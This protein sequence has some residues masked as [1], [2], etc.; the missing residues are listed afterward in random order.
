MVKFNFIARKKFLIT[1]LFILVIFSIGFFL[2]LETVSLT[3]IPGDERP[4]YQDDNG[5]PY[6]YELDSYYNYRL[7]ENYLEHGYLGDTI[8]NGVE[9]DLHSYYPPGVPL[10]Y[11]PLIVY[12]TAFVYKFVN[13]FTD[14]P[15]IVVCFWLSA[16]IAP[17]AGI[18]AYFFVGRFTNQYGAVAAGILTVTIPFYFIRTV[19]GWFDTDMFNLIFP[20]LVVWFLFEAFDNT[21]KSTQKG[22][23][24]SFLSA[25]SIFL[26]SMAWNG[27][28]YLFYLITIFWIIYIIWTL[29]KGRMVKN[30]LYNFAIF[31]GVS[32]GLVAVFTGFINIIKLAYAFLQLSTLSGGGP[33][34]DW[35]NV[36]TSV[37][38]LG[39]PS[40]EEISLDMGLSLF[41][42]LF[43]LIWIFRILLNDKLQQKFL[44]RMNWLSFSFLLLWTIM[45]FVTLKQG[46]RF[47]MILIPPLVVSTGIM[48]GICVE[49]LDL[50][51]NIRRI[52]IFRTKP[53]LIKVL[54]ILILLVAVLP[55][56]M[57][58][59]KGVLIVPGSNDEIWAAS[60]WINNN[61]ANNTVIISDWSNGHVYTAIADRPVSEDGRMGYLETLAVRNYS[62]LFPFKDKSPS[63]SREY[64]IDKALSTDNESLSVGILHMISTS[65]DEGYIKL[66]M[67]VK[68]TTK[69]VEIMNNIL[70]LD[71]SASRE[72]LVNNYGLEESQADEILKYT[73]PENPSPVVLVTNDRMI[74]T[75]QWIFKFGEWN[76]NEKHSNNYTYSVG[77]AN[78]TDDFINSTNDVFFD[79][80]TEN[81]TWKNRTPY[82]VVFI[83]N[84]TVEKSYM[85]SGSDF[86]IFLI[87]NKKAVVMDKR[88]ENS[89]FTK[90]V[91][92]KSNSTN[93]KSIYKNKSV[94][95]WE[96]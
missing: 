58:L 49:H 47:I 91:I 87:D 10:D 44:N 46:M 86:C 14:M 89:V 67:Y 57:H 33:W 84:G 42:G 50:L 5:L 78:K 40:L 30:N 12:L 92:E 16:F 9:W 53:G 83:N 70:G 72:L 62:N 79:F 69:T 65:G 88:F 24:F 2:R 38:E 25:F 3:G 22:I 96:M 17:L 18:V 48:V 45:G 41:V 20:F 1:V 37:S 64:W 95:V 43:G 76:F 94:I 26:F 51:K 54:A 71:R 68:N 61:T 74:G 75:G 35:P 77:T 8:I 73:H 6:M 90:L 19:P 34:P 23:L 59:E 15:L 56:I 81:I 39:V 36:Y 21:N 55:G 60:L 52:N 28:Q 27:W 66:D 93:F 13:L 82:C 7:T 29:F 85:D 63:S 32:L 4:F 11:P 31:V 80:K